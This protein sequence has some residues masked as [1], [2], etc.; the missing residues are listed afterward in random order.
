M[1]PD[2]RSPKFYLD[3]DDIAF[4][5]VLRRKYPVDAHGQHCANVGINDKVVSTVFAM[6]ERPRPKK[7][8]VSVLKFGSYPMLEAKG[9]GAKQNVVTEKPGSNTGILN[10]ERASVRPEL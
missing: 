2:R 3:H 9:D 5:T 4:P 8:G 1:F 6:E 10:S 7:K